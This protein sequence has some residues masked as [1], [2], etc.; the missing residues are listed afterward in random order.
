MG[1]RFFIEAAFMVGLFFVYKLIR[2]WV[3]GD[4]TEALANA[5]HVIG[6][7]RG[8]RLFT[9]PDFQ[10]LLL[11]QPEIVRA[12]N[13]YYIGMHFPTTI[14]CLGWLYV[15]R[16]LAYLS[17]R[18]VLVILTALG[19]V[20]H[21]LYPL[22]PPRMLPG[23]GFVDTGSVFGPN[24]YGPGG[25]FGGLAN[26]F[27]AMPSLHFGWAVVIAIAIVRSARSR[28]RW[29]IVLHPIATTAAIVGTANHYWMDAIVAGL[30]LGAVYAT[31]SVLSQAWPHRPGVEASAVTSAALD[32]AE[33][34]A[35]NPMVELCEDAQMC[36][37]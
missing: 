8:M 17:T 37:G 27:A 24:A 18:R 13:R 16:P 10:R 15:R 6:L 23:L 35:A 31:L 4:T 29:L 34:L 11:H 2:Y 22:A 3:Q 20:I 1:Y 36:S 28:W 21:V 26:Q 19:M 9:E 5:R 7:E 12:L 32:P 30:L 33:I 14:V 25:V